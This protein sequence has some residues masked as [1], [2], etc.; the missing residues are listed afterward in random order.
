MGL[1]ECLQDP[2]PQLC[3]G[4]ASAL[5]FKELD[6]GSPISRAQETILPSLTKQAFWTQRTGLQPNSEVLNLGCSLGSSG[7]GLGIFKKKKKCPG[8]PQNQLKHNP[9]AWDSDVSIFISSLV[10]PMN[11][12]GFKHL[13]LTGGRGTE[14]EGA[15]LCA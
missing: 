6:L 8:C 11:R 1:C 15:E 13:E 12:Q 10:I 4:L 14:L 2:D 7:V 3:V 9:W 5:G